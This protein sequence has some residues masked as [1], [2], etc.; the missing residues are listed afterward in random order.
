[1]DPE[2]IQKLFLKLRFDIS[3]KNFRFLLSGKL[4][5]SLILKYLIK[6]H[7]INPKLNEILV[8]KFMGFGVYANINQNIQVSAQFSEYTKIIWLY[9]QFGI[10]QS[11]DV[12]NFADENNLLIIE[13]CA[14]VLKANLDDGKSDI[15][16]SDYSIFSFSKFIDCAP[17]GGAQSTDK[18]FLSY[19]DNE[20]NQSSKIQSI[21][22]NNLWKIT[23]FINPNKLLYKKL[24]S[25]N[26]ALW[27]FPSKNLDNKINYCKKNIES[28]I[29]LRNK[30]FNFF[31][32]EIKEKIYQSYFNYENLVCQ[33]LPLVVENLNV[34]KNLI[35]KFEHYNFPYELLTYDKNRNFLNPKFYKTIMIDHSKNNPSFYK[36]IELIRKLA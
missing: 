26:H 33:K 11:I 12:K 29:D 35:E 15:L 14:H 23:S 1:M 21:L 28:E 19:L 24:T 6:K 4:A 13:D 18:I 34:Q 31:K 16:N 36:Q 3:D 30:N 22:I 7:N 8:P 20:I 2:N 5:S 25:L 10:P 17:L 27:N 9:H 32:K